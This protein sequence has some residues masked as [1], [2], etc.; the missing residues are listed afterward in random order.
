MRN[1]AIAAT[2]LCAACTATPHPSP[3]PQPREVRIV[4]EREAIKSCTPLGVVEASSRPDEKTV[5]DGP[6]DDNARHG[7]REVAAARGAN[8]VLLT[9]GRVGASYDATVRGE[10][11]SCSHIAS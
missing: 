8:V 7:L 1:V 4:S 3:A 5:A 9:Y 11:F 10:A 2:I 6:V